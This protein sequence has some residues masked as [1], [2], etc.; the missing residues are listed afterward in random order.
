MW[1][2]LNTNEWN[3]KSISLLDI[4][5][6]KKFKN[7]K[8]NIRNYTHR[9][10]LWNGVNGGHETTIFFFFL[11]E[12]WDNHIHWTKIYSNTEGSSHLAQPSFL[13]YF[14]SLLQV[15][16]KNMKYSFFINII[17]NLDRF[18]YKGLFRTHAVGWRIYSALFLISRSSFM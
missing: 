2:D 14:A 1:V 10:S 6:E 18:T 15:L 16:A 8:H 5:P 4:T 7:G 9:H 17:I 12:W 3:E 11:S 13:F